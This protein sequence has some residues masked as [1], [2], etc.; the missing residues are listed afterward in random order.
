MEINLFETF[1]IGVLLQTVITDSTI[2]K[3]AQ[4]YVYTCEI[5]I[6]HIHTCT[7]TRSVEICSLISTLHLLDT[8]MFK[9][10][11]VLKLMFCFTYV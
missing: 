4:T 11:A 10:E 6:R 3:Q 8:H 2:R 9:H 5:I 1:D 7:C